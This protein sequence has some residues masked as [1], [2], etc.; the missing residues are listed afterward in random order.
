MRLDEWLRHATTRLD[1]SGV[2]SPRLEA[3]VLAAHV[4]RVDRSWLLSHP[5]HDFPE[6]AGEMLLQRREAHEPLAYL[7]GYRE[8]RGREFGVD[9]S[10]LIPRHE[11]EELVE[12]ALDLWQGPNPKCLDLG[13]GSG[14]L[15]ITLKLERPDWEVTAVDI[16]PEALATASANARF[17][18]ANVRFILSDGFGALLGESFDLIVSNPPYIGDD[19]ELPTEVRDHE[20]A[21][22]LFSGPTGLEFYGRLANE[23]P[24]HLEDGGL[25]LLEVGHTQASEVRALFEG[26]GWK[27]ETTRRDLSGVE[28][29]VGFRWSYDCAA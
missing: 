21:G 24:A 19:E 22:A 20:P 16:S 17:H 27:H 9:P 8:F 13:T 2:E 18:N 28:R 26:A 6:I 11:T 5:E 25:I 4:L 14:I 15:A 7:T 3:Q 29:V 10:V 12:A 23:A 1:L